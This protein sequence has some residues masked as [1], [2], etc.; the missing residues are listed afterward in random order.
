MF[1][2]FDS[3][4]KWRSHLHLNLVLKIWQIWPISKESAFK[5]PMTTLNTNEMLIVTLMTYWKNYWTPNLLLLFSMINPKCLISPDISSFGMSNYSK[6]S[7]YA[8]FSYISSSPV[9][10]PSKEL[11]SGKWFMLQLFLLYLIYCSKNH[12]CYYLVLDRLLFL[13]H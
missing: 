7:R 11:S 2:V 4:K 9:P 1:I 10:S 13:Y 12:W 3:V 6:S 5:L 8:S